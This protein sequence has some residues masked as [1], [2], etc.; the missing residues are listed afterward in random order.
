[1]ILCQTLEI[2]SY[3]VLNSLPL[4]LCRPGRSSTHPQPLATPLM[5]KTYRTQVKW[6][7]YTKLLSENLKERNSLKN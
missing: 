1:M 5:G 6:E 4:G 2:F 3:N 7:I